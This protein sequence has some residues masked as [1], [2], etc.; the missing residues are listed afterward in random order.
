MWRQGT[1]SDMGAVEVSIVFRLSARVEASITS[2]LQI[3]RYVRE[4]V[5]TY[6]EQ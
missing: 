4:T 2:V 3:D 5:K 6:L 1:F